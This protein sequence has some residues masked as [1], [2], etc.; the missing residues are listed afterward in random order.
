[1]KRIVSIVLVALML[2]SVAT[3]TAFAQRSSDIDRATPELDNNDLSVAYQK[4]DELCWSAVFDY[5]V[6]S[7]DRNSPYKYEPGVLVLTLTNDSLDRGREALDDTSDF[8]N[9]YSIEP[10]KYTL[11]D[12]ENQY[13]KLKST[14]DSLVFS[15]N[16]L[17]ALIE[18]CFEEKNDTG[19][20]SEELWNEFTQKLSNAQA[21]YDNEEIVEDYR[22]TEAYF[23]LLHSHFKLCSSNTMF[24]DV[25][26]D[27]KISIVDATHLQR[28]LAEIEFL[29]SSQKLIS[30]FDL[31]YAT[32][33]QRY[34]VMLESTLDIDNSTLDVYAQYTKYSDIHTQSFKF[35][36]WKYN[37]FYV[38]YIS[39]H[40]YPTY[41]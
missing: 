40:N 26:N 14:L 4:L 20:Y 6:S 15:K 28:A 1:M 29:N 34:I 30:K 16:T 37:Y 2:F 23:E 33:I 11:D 12:F 24:G 32:K 19:Y 39:D 41:L 27:G 7:T 31:L 22:V 10:E 3:M 36:S 13:A 5:G 9:N 38:S 25:D 8:L 17:R 21:V 18:F 35:K